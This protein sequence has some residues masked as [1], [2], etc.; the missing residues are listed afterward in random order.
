MAKMNFKKFEAEVVNSYNQIFNNTQT[1]QEDILLTNDKE[2]VFLY[3]YF[4]HKLRCGGEFTEKEKIVFLYLTNK[5]HNRY[6]DDFDFETIKNISMQYS[7][8]YPERKYNQL[9]ISHTLK[10]KKYTLIPLVASFISAYDQI[11]FYRQSV[12]HN[13]AGVYIQKV[14]TLRATQL[15]IL[16]AMLQKVEVIYH[17]CF[18][19]YHQFIDGDNSD[20]MK[21]YC[22]IEMLVDEYENHKNINNLINVANDLSYI[23][24]KNYTPQV[25]GEVGTAPQ[26][27][28]S[29]ENYLTEEDDVESADDGSEVEPEGEGEKLDQGEL[30]K[31]ND[32]DDDIEPI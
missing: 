1:I 32:D 23:A 27:I 8:K 13:T 6:G 7:L 29:R 17:D 16:N 25:P 18:R 9:I 31:E 11:L 12:I 21:A 2:E 28:Q 3:N 24:L 10:D 20:K 14:N 15:Y 30:E 22:Q 19:Y 26:E 5:M 4:N